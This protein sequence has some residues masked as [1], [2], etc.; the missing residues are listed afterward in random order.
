MRWEGAEA[1]GSLG[2]WVGGGRGSG[3]VG[4]VSWGRGR[5]L[6]FASDH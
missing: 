3:E 2:T 1:K 5:K 6:V 4:K